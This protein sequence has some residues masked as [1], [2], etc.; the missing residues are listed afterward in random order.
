[1]VLVGLKARTIA[2]RLKALTRA[3]FLWTFHPSGRVFN[4]WP[5]KHLQVL[6][7]F[8]QAERKSRKAG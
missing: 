7:V 5:E 6:E 2:V 8:R 3:E 1:V 4:I